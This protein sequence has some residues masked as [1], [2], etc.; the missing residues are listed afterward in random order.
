VVAAAIRDGRLVVTGVGDSRAYWLGARCRQLTLDDSW[1]A[2]QLASG[3][4]A[5]ADVTL[6]PR[7]NA[8]TRWIGR[9]APDLAPAVAAFDVTPGGRV[10]LCSDGLSKYVGTPR[11][12]RSLGAGRGPLGAAAA[13]VD[14]ALSAGGRDNV[15]VAVI[16]VPCEGG[17]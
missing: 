11:E 16:D 15:T 7:A 17:M 1:A 13:L 9:D 6:D 8:V 10:V 5:P 14:H 2:E 3:L 12:L 4:S